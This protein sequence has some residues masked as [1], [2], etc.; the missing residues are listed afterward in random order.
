MQMLINRF[1]KPGGAGAI[2]T[3]RKVGGAG[4]VAALDRRPARRTASVVIVL[5]VEEADSPPRPIAV[6]NVR[7][8]GTDMVP[9]AL[10]EHLL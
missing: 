2:L 10:R 7:A 4:V 8:T 1:C 9:A 5:V 6:R 3:E